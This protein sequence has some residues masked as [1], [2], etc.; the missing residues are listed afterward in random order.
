MNLDS[1]QFF[2]APAVPITRIL[3]VGF[4]LVSLTIFFLVHGMIVSRGGIRE[5]EGLE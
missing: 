3:T 5:G 2:P 4:V 1:R